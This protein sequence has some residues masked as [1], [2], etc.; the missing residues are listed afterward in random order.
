MASASSV[1]RSAMVPTITSKY[2]A[3]VT[4]ATVASDK[5]TEID[6]RAALNAHG[7][8]TRFNPWVSD[9]KGGEQPRQQFRR[10]PTREFNS[11][12]LENTSESFVTAFAGDANVPG[13]AMGYKNHATKAALSNGIG[14][15]VTTAAVIYDD[16]PTMGDNVSLK[17]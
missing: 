7:E 1:S 12:L 5:V 10:M 3:G 16:V 8:D 2:P 17:L 9:N 14:S 4:V 15:Y 13:A 6:E 11:A